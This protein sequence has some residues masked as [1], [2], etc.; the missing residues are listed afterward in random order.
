MELWANCVQRLS[1]CNRLGV[2]VGTGQSWAPICLNKEA[3]CF[4]SSSLKRV[5]SVEL[6]AAEPTRMRRYFW[7]LLPF[8]RRHTWKSLFWRWR[9][10]WHGPGTWVPVP[11]CPY[12][13]KRFETEAWFMRITMIRI[14]RCGMLKHQTTLGTDDRQ[15][16]RPTFWNS[17]TT[18]RQLRLRR[19]DYRDSF[20]SS[21]GYWYSILLY[22]VYIVDKG[23]MVY[24]ALVYVSPSCPLGRRYIC[25]QCTVLCTYNM[26]SVWSVPAQKQCQVLQHGACLGIGAV[27]GCVCSGAV[28][29]K[30]M[31]CYAAQLSEVFCVWQ[32]LM[33]ESMTNSHRLCG[34]PR[35]HTLL[36]CDRF[37][38]HSASL[39]IIIDFGFILVTFVTFVKRIKSSDLLDTTDSYHSSQFLT[40][41]EI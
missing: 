16:V 17:Y 2:A 6:R 9:L 8:C 27:L 3:A 10:V 23:Y 18:L 4:V 31:L 12:H 38:D 15:L 24:Q 1:E 32:Q 26:F 39:K 36:E 34:C 20:G 7:I 19:H 37:I 30:G 11:H 29:S 40:A 21:C 14:P 22:T 25:V 35:L 33:N 41:S 13:L 28:C 5:E